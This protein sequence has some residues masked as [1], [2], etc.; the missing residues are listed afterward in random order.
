M[1]PTSDDARSGAETTATEVRE[2]DDD[3]GPRPRIARLRALALG[4]VAGAVA[5]GVMTA[6]RMPISHSLPPTGPF[7][8]K[9]VGGG[10]PDQY[11]REALALHLLYGTGAGAVF[12][13]AVSGAL[14]G[15]KSEVERERRATALGVSYGLALSAFGM[16]FL[17]ERLLEMDLDPDERLLFHLGH[18]VYGLTL[19]AWFG[20]NIYSSD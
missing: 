17:L 20:S 15:A 13:V 10:D 11:V 19:G 16:K 9:Y 6:F 4:S 8:A 14:A 18:V 5:T 1:F 3:A 7:W 12:G 2:S